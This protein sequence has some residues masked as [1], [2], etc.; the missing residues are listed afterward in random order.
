MFHL[1][2]LPHPGASKPGAQQVRRGLGGAVLDGYPPRLPGRQ[3]QGPEPP[4]PNP[5]KLRGGRLNPGVR[6]ID[7][8]NEGKCAAATR[9]IALTT[10]VVLI[11]ADLSQRAGRNGGAAKTHRRDAPKDHR[12]KC[13]EV[14]TQVASARLARRAIM[15]CGPRRRHRSSG[16]R[17]SLPWRRTWHERHLRPPRPCRDQ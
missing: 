11:Y 7:G 4:V 6:R 9:D 1:S 5:R 17:L 3:S 12:I 14:R 8:A 15:P 13:K 2:H 16:N 10:K